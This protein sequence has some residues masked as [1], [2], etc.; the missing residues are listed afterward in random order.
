MLT[1][2]P[3]D[4][5]FCFESYGVN[6]C[7]ESHRADLLREAQK[8]V[9][10]ALVGSVRL[11]EKTGS[12]H[13]IGIGRRN[14][15][16]YFVR[17]RGSEF[18]AGDTRNGLMKYLDTLVRFKI[19]EFAVDHVF[20][21]AGVVG[22]NGKAIVFPADSNCG[23]TTLTAELVRNGATYYSDDFAVFDSQG[24][25]HPFARGLSVRKKSRAWKITDI[26]VE[27]IGGVAGTSP[28]PVG[29]VFLT[30]YKDNARWKPKMLTPGQGMVEMIRQTIPIRY[31]PE[32]SMKV[33][34]KITSGATIVK[35]YRSEAK[36]AAKTILEFVDRN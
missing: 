21:H 9:R 16:W 27:S 32:F 1:N 30:K 35:G 3:L 23:K 29:F 7:I 20:V 15:G 36:D 28:L 33:L 8:R 19:A 2:R 24:M 12:E 22:W 13:I 34:K 26:D 31:A 25:V 6:V 17:D 4:K 14:D 11:I 18:V 10:K 5:Y